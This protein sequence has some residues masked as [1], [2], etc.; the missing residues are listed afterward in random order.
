MTLAESA[1]MGIAVPA[2]G[3]YTITLR[4]SLDRMVGARLLRLVDAR[5]QMATY[6][7][8]V[9]RHVLLDVS[10]LEAVAPG[11]EAALRHAAHAC[12]RR[13]ITFDLVGAAAVGPHLG[14]G[15]RQ[16]LARYRSFPDVPAA[17]AA[18]SD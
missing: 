10:G 7:H 1:P 14:I 6:G 17:V 15:A 18:L 2:A 12:D 11:G 4:G 3:F 16:A 8:A 9:T 5:L 13:G